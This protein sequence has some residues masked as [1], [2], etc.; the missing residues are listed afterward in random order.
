MEPRSKEAVEGLATTKVVIGSMELKNIFR[1]GLEN[2]IYGKK[3]NIE[4]EKGRV[5][6]GANYRGANDRARITKNKKNMV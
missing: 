5:S 1:S 3:P 4:E 6:W 2:Q